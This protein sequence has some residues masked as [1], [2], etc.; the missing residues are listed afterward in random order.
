MPSEDILDLL[1]RYASGSLTEQ[2]RQR[3]FDAALNDQN[4][5]EQLA[6]EQEL[7]MYLEEPGARDRMIRAL[8]PGSRKTAWIFSG[9]IAAA[10]AVIL[11]AFVLRPSP[12]PP[13]I[14]RA[15]VPPTPVAVAPETAA[16]AVETKSAAKKTERVAEAAPGNA[17]QTETVQIQ[18]APQQDAAAPQMA[19]QRMAAAPAA[20]RIASFGFHYSLYTRSHLFIVPAADGYL[21]VKSDDGTV[22]NR[23]QI[24]AGIRTDIVL[25]DA[26]K[27]LTIT[28][29]V[30]A[31]PVEI[32]PVERAESSGDVAGSSPLAVTVKIK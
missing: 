21:F 10:L 15:I 5:F 7:K 29:S 25:P 9:A 14:A 12:R 11:V 22:L 8:G 13:Q 20:R 19:S 16:P 18:A 30:D 2:E 4:L 26:A 1:G 17:N 3:L 31:T 27:S 23:T 6:Q 28:F 32:K 24:A